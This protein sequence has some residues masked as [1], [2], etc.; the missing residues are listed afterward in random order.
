MIKPSDG[1]GLMQ[2]KSSERKKVLILLF[3]TGND[4]SSKI[5][6]E[7]YRNILSASF[8]RDGTKRI[9]HHAARD[10]KPKQPRSS[11]AERSNSLVVF[12]VLTSH[13]NL[14]T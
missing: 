8:K 7:D 12:L 3:F 13:A 1:S 14:Q 6:S 4:S 11:S 9:L 10:N 5:H 2:T